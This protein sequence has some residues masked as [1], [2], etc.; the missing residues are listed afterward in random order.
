MQPHK[1]IYPIPG[2]RKEIHTK[3]NETFLQIL[4][5]N[6]KPLV[7]IN[8]SKELFYCN[9]LPFGISVALGIFQRAVFSKAC[10]ISVFLDYVQLRGQTKTEHLQNLK[11]WPNSYL[12]ACALRKKVH[13][14]H[15]TLYI[16]NTRLIQMVYMQQRRNNVSLLRHYCQSQYWNYYVNFPPYIASELGPLYK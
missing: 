1:N 4:P 8:T 15:V 7:T 16:Q 14:K 5:E 9:W 12:Q 13:S 3:I 11:Y 2:R 10:H 6:S